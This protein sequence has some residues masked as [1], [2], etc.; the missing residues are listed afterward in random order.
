M[1]K[2]ATNTTMF[3]RMRENMDVNAGAIVDGTRTLEQV[4]DEIFD[5]M[6][7]Q[8]KLVGW[9]RKLTLSRDP[10]SLAVDV[11]SYIVQ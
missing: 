7:D 3:E 9:D 10:L 1:I 4:G 2:V 8:M 5:W 11:G 6:R